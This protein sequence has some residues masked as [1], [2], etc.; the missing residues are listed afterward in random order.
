MPGLKDLIR[1]NLM[2][3][4]GKSPFF[5]NSHDTDV[6][7]KPGPEC[8]H[9]D[10]AF[11]N[12][13]FSL[14]QAWLHGEFKEE[15][16]KY[17]A[18]KAIT[19]EHKTTTP[20]TPVPRLNFSITD[21]KERAQDFKNQLRKLDFS[22]LVIF[23]REKPNMLRGKIFNLPETHDER[24]RWKNDPENTR[25]IQELLLAVDVLNEKRKSPL[26]WNVAEA[27][28]G[29]AIVMGIG[30]GFVHLL[31]PTLFGGAILH[32]IAPTATSVAATKV[33]S[34]IPYALGLF[35]LGLITKSL[36]PTE[37]KCVEKAYYN[38]MK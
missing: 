28:I 6:L 2:I 7:T 18:S 4:K 35:G 33:T 26:L 11:Y 13:E 3:K 30:L 12:L 27:I 17:K 10:V 32:L 34:A 23:V 36:I 20:P 25:D 15:N 31:G 24:E 37:Q 9:L 38:A 21:E 22:K 1:H 16:D 5:S 8:G 14:Q 29:L 19:A